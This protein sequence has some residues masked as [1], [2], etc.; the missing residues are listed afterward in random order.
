MQG[1]SDKRKAVSLVEI[2][3]VVI[4]MGIASLAI[5]NIIS[6]ARYTYSQTEA[7]GNARQDAS[8]IM[9]YLE[10]DVT[11]S[12]SFVDPNDPAKV[13]KTLEV[14]GSN[15]T[16]SVPLEELDEDA[17]YFDSNIDREDADYHE[18]RYELNGTNFARIVENGP[19]R[20]LSKFVK[21]FEVQETYDGKI[22][23]R[24]LVE[25]KLR[26]YEEFQTHQEH[27]VFTVREASQTETDTRWR[28]RVDS[29]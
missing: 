10:R 2:M 13:I 5:Y 4:V 21:E 29:Y 3:V 28:Q 14:N 25:Y 24:I 20:T 18:I 7:R 23:V 19:T 17:T 27:A 6:R 15:L 12:R 22:S 11:N 9:R 26:G 8:T 16:M 1:R